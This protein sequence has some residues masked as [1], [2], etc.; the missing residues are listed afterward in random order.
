MCDETCVRLA[1]GIDKRGWNGN[2]GVVRALQV[3]YVNRNMHLWFES[4]SECDFMKSCAKIA[5]K[6]RILL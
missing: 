5:F 2:V 6:C 3:P 4:L 1:H